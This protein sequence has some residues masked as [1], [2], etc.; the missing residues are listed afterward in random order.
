M[1]ADEG[2][3][4]VR[5][6]NLYKFP[7]IDGNVVACLVK[8][9]PLQILD[10]NEEFFKVRFQNQEAYIPKQCLRAAQVERGI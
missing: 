8:G 10:D 9:T 4:R 1:A 3:I 7:V 6:T 5:Y 2:I